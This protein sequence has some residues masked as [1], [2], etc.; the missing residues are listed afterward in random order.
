MW[1]PFN[2]LITNV[3]LKTE[4]QIMTIFHLPQHDDVHYKIFIFYF[5]PSHDQFIK[6]YQLLILN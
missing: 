1:D 6:Q 2:F 5:P 3:M 4:K